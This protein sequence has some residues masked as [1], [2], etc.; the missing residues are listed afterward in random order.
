M[1][2]LVIRSPDHPRAIANAILDHLGGKRFLAMTGA[3]DLLAIESGLS[4]RLPPRLAHDRITHIEI[5]LELLSRYTVFFER[6]SRSG[7]RV[8]HVKKITGVLP[9]Q[10]QTRFH[11]ITGLATMLASIA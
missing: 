1:S 8:E 7:R 11:Q 2:S 4:F 10:L 3:S 6:T 9:E 5:Q